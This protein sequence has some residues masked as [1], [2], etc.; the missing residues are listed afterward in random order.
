M[1]DFYAS[2]N[3]TVEITNSEVGLS[4]WSKYETVCFWRMAEFPTQSS[5]RIEVREVSLT[6]DSANKTYVAVSISADELP[7][8]IRKIDEE[9]RSR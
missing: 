2:R 5:L 7:K 6:K 8:T 1:Y 4:G 3:K 9:Y